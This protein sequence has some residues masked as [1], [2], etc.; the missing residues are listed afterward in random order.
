MNKSKL[1]RNYGWKPQLPDVRDHQFV[2]KTVQSLKL[3]PH[4][5]L[6]NNFMPV[7]V[8]QG[9]LGSCVSN[10]VAGLFEYTTNKQKLPD[11]APSRLFIYY[12]GRVIENDVPQDNGLTVRDGVKVVKN[13]GVCPEVD[14]TYDITAFASQPTPTDYQIALS[15]KIS[16]YATVAQTMNTLK[17]TL[18]E[19]YPIVFGFT[20]YDSFESDAV[21]AS[22]VVPMPSP[23]ES[24]LGGHCVL[25]VGY[26]DPSQRF[27]CR[28]SWGTSWG[29]SGYFTIP[30]SYVANPNLASDFWIITSVTGA[31]PQP[32]TTTTTTTTSSSTT[33]TTTINPTPNPLISELEGLKTEINTIEQQIENNGLHSLPITKL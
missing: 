2:P 24:V 10:A 12:N 27:I 21:A 6:R 26:D 18:S 1:N 19:G 14:W 20:V 17:L 31:N 29:M 33:T 7:V 15:T 32:T 4:I 8:D 28:N 16:A 3:A 9:Q 25:I 22:G 13:Q 23:T 30:Y 5:D 11:F